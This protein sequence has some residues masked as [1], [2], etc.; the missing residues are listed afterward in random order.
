MTSE[1][2]HA[3]S[4]G[5]ARQ[6]QPLWTFTGPDQTTELRVDA[7]PGA[8]PHAAVRGEIDIFTAPWLREELLRVTQRHGA[9][10]VLDLSG[11]TFMDCAGINVLLA[12]RRRAQL[13]G[14]WLRLTDVS[15]AVSRIIALAGLQQVLTPGTMSASQPGISG[16][17]GPGRRP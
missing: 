12:T 13:A 2:T 16:S 3:T 4:Q 8:P 17:P 6:G 11:V 5:T 7:S 10:L 14:G 9:R 1:L 15:P